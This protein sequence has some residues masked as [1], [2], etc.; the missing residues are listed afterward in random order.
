M[1]DV[2]LTKGLSL[3][4]WLD[5]ENERY[6]RALGVGSSM[7]KTLAQQSALHLHAKMTRP[8]EVSAATQATLDFGT[9]VH[10]A[11]LEP[12]VYKQLYVA[13]PAFGRKAGTTIAAQ[14]AEWANTQQ[15]KR[16]ASQQD[17]QKAEAMSH[18]IHTH[19]YA[20]ALLRGGLK[21][22]SAW[23]VDK[24]TSLCCKFRPDCVSANGKFIVDIKTTV[25]VSKNAFMR[26]AD[27][28]MY[29]LQAAHYL[30]GARATGLA[31]DA[32]F[33]FVAVEKTAPFAVVVYEPSDLFLSL[34]EDWRRYCMKR[35][36]ECKKSDVW[37]G[38]EEAQQLDPPS[39]TK[40]PPVY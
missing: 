16:I 34:G 18:A 13:E 5:V 35:Y 37:P 10:A 21:E 28:L 38:P 39:W 19:P 33:V 9:M 6:H 26:Q 40:M 20:K 22:K 11:A 31:P 30:Q 32:K 14:K 8:Q 24:E 25:D 17:M 4:E 23:W 1:S 3:N 7:L 12:D 36:A 29:H 2:E 15:G 27:N